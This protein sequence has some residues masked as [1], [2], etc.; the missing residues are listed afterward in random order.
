MILFTLQNVH[1]PPNPSIPRGALQI[2]NL[3]PELEA[4]DKEIDQLV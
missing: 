2:H 3:I 1:N 4:L